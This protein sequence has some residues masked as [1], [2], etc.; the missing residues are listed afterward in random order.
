MEKPR[1]PLLILGTRTLAIEIADLA[2]EIPGIE[3]AGFVENTEPEKC[4]ETLE[5]LPVYWVEELA[6]LRD[7][8]MVVG[9]LATTHRSVFIEQA[10]ARG[11][12]FAT[13]V[14][15]LARVSAKAHLGAGAIIGPGSIVSAHTRIGC[16]VFVNRGVLIGHHTAI[17]DFSTLQPGANIAGCC[18][19]A[20]HVYVGMG[21]T[22]VDNI[23]V[24]AHSFVGAGS[25]VT[26]D[27][28]SHVRVFGVPAKV[29]RENFQGK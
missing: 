19:I 20:E 2:S 23:A 26:K 4:R 16:H 15:P 12:E 24:G 6:R 27:F 9:G 18:R 28:P 21:A 14:H 10:A 3:V 22:I 5:G 7:A 1:R 29:I 25:L 13:L 8:H 11:M 17:G